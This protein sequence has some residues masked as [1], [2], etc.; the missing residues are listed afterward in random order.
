MRNKKLLMRQ[1]IIACASIVCLV[2]V[3]FFSY[4]SVEKMIISREEE[5]MKSLAKVNARS[6]FST[7]ESKRDLVY[8]AFSGDMENLDEIE[9]GSIKMGERC[10]YVPLEEVRKQQEWEQKQCAE[11]LKKPGE[12]AIGPIEQTEEEAYVLYM[13]KTISVRGKIT[14]YVRVQLDLDEIYEEEQAL[15]ALE[16]EN[17]RYCIVQNEAG[18]TIMPGAY[19]KEDISISHTAGKGSTVKWIYETNGGALKNTKKLIACET[20]TIGEEKLFLYIIENYNELVTPLERISLDFSLIGILLVVTAI[21]FIYKLQEHHKKET[22]L[23]KEL[24]HEKT[25]NE[26]MKKQEGL[27]KK[28]NHSKTLGVLT[29]AIAHEFNNL[30]TPIVLYAELLEENEVVQKEMPDEINELKTSA[31][32]CGELARQLLDYSRQGKAEKVLTDYDAVYAMHEAIN[33]VKKI[34][35]ENIVLQ[36]NICKT[37]YKIHGQVGSLNQIVLNLATNAVHAMKKGGVLKIEFGLSTDDDKFVR[38]IIE[39]SG[40]GIPTEIK[41]KVFQPFFTTKKMSEGTGIGLTV[42]KRLTE[43][44]G[45][46]I[47][48]KTEIGK[49]TMFIVDFPYTIEETEKIPAPN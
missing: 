27:M 28:Y 17:G 43:E 42:V 39:D 32:R 46:T 29:G 12:V 14:G 7:L 3:V 4:S 18:E 19:R 23:V 40:E 21:G 44:H 47:R 1:I 15:S 16:T 49:G 2:G 9:T 20:I 37:P 26:T 36:E 6:L 8:A 33:I 5:N 41:Q 45:G 30:M 24:Q 35:P 48:V 38:L 13:L 31:V 25:L 10:E 22:E 11:M 34:L